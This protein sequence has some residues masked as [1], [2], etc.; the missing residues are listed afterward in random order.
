MSRLITFFT[1]RL[2]V[3]SAVF[4]MI[5]VASLASFHRPGLARV[6]SLSATLLPAPLTTVAARTGV[7]SAP[8]ITPAVPFTLSQSAAVFLKVATV[9]DAETPAGVLAVTAS[10]VPSG[11][12]FSSIVNNNGT[13]SAF[14]SLNCTISPGNY[15]LLLTVKDG[16]N[17]TASAPLDFTIVTN[18]APNP[19]AYPAVTLNRG[20]TKL[21][22]PASFSEQDID[23]ITVT[24][25]GFSGTFR[26]N[27]SNGEITIYNATPP[28]SYTVTVTM[29][30]R[31][32]LSTTRTFPLTV[33]TTP[34]PVPCLN[35]PSATMT[36]YGLGFDLNSYS[37]DNFNDDLVTGDFNGDGRLDLAAINPKRP[38]G[39]IVVLLADGNGRFIQVPGSPLTGLS[40]PIAIAAADFNGDGRADLAVA[41]RL[42]AD[43][44]IYL[45]ST[46]GRFA[47]APL[48]TA[49]SQYYPNSLLAGDFNHDG[50]AD[51][52]L[53]TDS[54]GSIGHVVV[55]LGDGT[56]KFSESSAPGAGTFPAALA[57]GDFNRDGNLDVACALR[58]FPATTNAL[59]LLLGDGAGGFSQINGN[60]ATLGS[61][62]WSM[63]AGDFNGD[64]NP[65]LAIT[66]LVANNVMILL[67]NGSGAFTQ[68]PGSPFTTAY[69]TSLKIADVNQDSKT[70]LI[71]GQVSTLS[72]WLGN[73]NGTFAQASGSPISTSTYAALAA[74]FTG[75]G[76]P[77]LAVLSITDGV[78]KILPGNGDGT[79][80][81][82]I[83]PAGT[84][85]RINIQA[86][87]SRQQGQADALNV[88]T[89][90]DAETA[91]TGLNVRAVTVPAGL[92]VRSISNNNGTVQAD[93]S[94]ACNL[95]PDAYNIVLRVTDE[96]GL[97]ADG[98]L[99]VNVTANT[100]PALGAYQVA[101]VSPGATATLAPTSPPTDNGTVTSLTA[102]APGFTGSFS[103]SSSTGVITISN[104]GPVGNYI[105]TI[106]ATDN[107]GA[108]ASTSF[109]LTVGAPPVI[110]NLA[111]GEI[112]RQAARVQW[113][114][115]QPTTGAVQYAL[116]NGPFTYSASDSGLKTA[117]SVIISP[118]GSGQT[119]RVRVVAR[120]TNNLEAVS[121]I[122][123]FTTQQRVDLAIGSI[124]LSNPA[125]AAGA[126]LTATVKV[127]NDGDVTAT[128]TLVLT[129]DSSAG[130]REISRSQLSL[131][132]NA[133]EL[134]VTSPAFP[135]APGS[136]SITAQLI[137]ISPGDGIAENN[138]AS[139]EAQV[140]AP[141]SRLTVAVASQQTWPG[142]DSNFTAVVTNTGA[143]AQTISRAEVT[144][145]SWVT[146]ASPLPAAPLEPGE[147]AQLVFR[148][149]PPLDE[150]GGPA[151]DPVRKV[152]TL[153][154]NG[155]ASGTNFEIAIY[156][157][158]VTTLN[159][160][161]VDAD[162]KQPLRG[163]IIGLSNTNRIYR[164]DVN[165]K[166]V[167]ATGQP[168]VIGVADDTVNVFF[169]FADYLTIARSVAQIK[170]DNGIVELTSGRGLEIL[171]V[172]VRELS[173]AEIA[174]QSPT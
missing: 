171:D 157:G 14:I 32:G 156:N 61:N 64:G 51:L 26:P 86:A 7:F 67:G 16:E 72:V 57:T 41:D 160:M 79:F 30:D 85:P 63:G 119:Y 166:P 129:D 69:P 127:R 144:G 52:V 13:I 146:L 12:Q 159:L 6:R 123:S 121:Q 142:D 78:L 124:T 115:D 164:T 10:N 35:A 173:A 154:L 73:G 36:E 2:I 68:A 17:L 74:D 150:P 4:L 60:A 136:H 65:D 82:Q 105:V 88:A 39:Q 48:L 95:A 113:T 83:V 96:C 149:T 151:S 110:S 116:G 70:D 24:T 117:H 132:A 153:R 97:T 80:I 145:V 167:D 155:A 141:A 42:S 101:T 71:I 114:T 3:L 148:L 50:K 133:P 135:L 140:N 1:R 92:T 53:G 137:S 75:D 66:D 125:P 112:T 28:G 81:S 152:V 15:T 126:S 46:N 108:T 87:I 169:A 100:A 102:A 107:C 55:L 131:A 130:S 34:A 20:E 118:L 134:R 104:A 77:D 168:V 89:I 103:A 62:S 11:I 84:A 54:F 9:A 161:V 5:A 93:I 56:G 76:K 120:N 19:G 43:V 109:A 37:P 90:S 22:A 45:A 8:S 128:A 122:L 147:S 38:S 44:K 170:T 49:R 99:T 163:A 143:A 165:G 139:V 33:S 18:Q 25:S 91:V 138:S 172:Q 174:A 111:V 40:G 98:T 31:C 27:N 59:V 23:W 94:A 21:I 29:M 106:T 47:S 158:P 162:T 58:N